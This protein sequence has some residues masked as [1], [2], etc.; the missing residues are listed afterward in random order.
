MSRPFLISARR[1]YG[2]ARRCRYWRVRRKRCAG[3]YAPR[4]NQIPRE[5][6]VARKE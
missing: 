4:T 1:R 2:L 6:A 3:T 5:V